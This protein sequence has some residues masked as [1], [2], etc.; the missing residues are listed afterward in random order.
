[1]GRND[2][3]VDG[4]IL[5]EYLKDKELIKDEIERTELFKSQT[6][7]IRLGRHVKPKYESKKEKNGKVKILGNREKNKHNYERYLL[8]AIKSKK[9][10]DAFVIV[11]VAHP[12]ETIFTTKIV[13]DII[14]KFCM[15]NNIVPISKSISHALRGRVGEIRKSELSNY[16]FFWERNTSLNKSNILKYGIK[17][18]YLNELT[19]DEAINSANER[20]KEFKDKNALLNPKRSVNKNAIRPDIKTAPVE[21]PVLPHP[22]APSN[23]ISE[24]MTQLGKL[25]SDKKSI[26]KV[27]GD[28]HIHINISR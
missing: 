3:T 21:N 2:I 6:D 19:I 13:A 8:K 28:L 17:E 16:M 27:E 10:L 11:M 15:E 22:E 20:R 1:M 14:N 7:T 23:L 12:T 4:V 25:Q 9:L 18:T 24:I 26:I 5:P